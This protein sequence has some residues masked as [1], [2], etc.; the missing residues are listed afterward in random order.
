[1][2]PLPVREIV[3][4]AL[5]V[6]LPPAP[7]VGAIGAGGGEI[8]ADAGEGRELGETDG[9]AVTEAGFGGTTALADSAAIAFF[10]LITH[11]CLCTSFIL[12]RVR[13]L[14]CTKRDPQS[15]H[16]YSF[17]FDTMYTCN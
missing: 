11:N 16:T 7:T 8:E 12:S 10:L 1:L 5:L 4:L 17:K 9:F 2:V 13:E 14:L 15:S 3:V 6:V